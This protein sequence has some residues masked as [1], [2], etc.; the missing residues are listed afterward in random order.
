MKIYHQATLVYIQNRPLSLPS[1]D[2]LPV[3]F[4]KWIPKNGLTGLAG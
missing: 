4:E 1:F 3:N 2:H